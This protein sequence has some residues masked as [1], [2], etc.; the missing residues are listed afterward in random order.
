MTGIR[1]AIIALSIFS[2]WSARLAAGPI[3]I[4]GGSFETPV[5]NYVNINIDS[6]Q[7]APKPAWYVE[8]GGFL[9]TQ[10]AGT[11]RNT[12]STETDHIDNCDGNQ[13]IWL[14][15]VPEVALFQDYD[16]VDWNDPVPTHAFDARFEIGKSYTLTVGIIG[17]GGG[18][19]EG[20]SMEIGMY[21]REGGGSKVTV[22]ATSVVNT[23]NTFPTNTHFVDFQVRVP[24]V[25]PGDAWAGK[26]IGV[27]FLST[28]PRVPAGQPSLQG[29]YWDLD[30]V[31]LSSA[32]E[33]PFVVSSA[34]ESGSLRISWPS[35]TG[36][37]YQVEKSDDLQTWATY[38]TSL[39]GTGADLFKLYPLAGHTN[40]FFR[41]TVSAV[42]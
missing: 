37:Q 28:I 3:N 40:G 24:V 27:R 38:E 16:S 6:W 42:P 7:K 5:T 39:S 19:L 2:A 20:A 35:A 21:H 14:F 36:Y 4:P 29:G 10:L 17:G 8:G 13:A 34:R 33:P 18:M 11:F 22:A 30:N 1:R 31:R 25:K 41:V 26:N 15:A 12:A 32:A 23:L 9:W